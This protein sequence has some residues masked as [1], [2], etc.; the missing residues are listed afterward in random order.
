MGVAG[1]TGLLCSLFL[2]FQFA[3][4]GEIRLGVLKF[5]IVNWELDVM[6]HNGLAS[7]EGVDL[8]VV[9]VANKNATSVA[10]QAREVGMIVTDWIW[11]SR[12]RATMHLDSG[13]SQ[14]MA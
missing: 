3:I 8:T 9:P 6:V 13:P 11:V 10:L 7:A 12:Q 14:H 1:L 2:P 4:A 5:G